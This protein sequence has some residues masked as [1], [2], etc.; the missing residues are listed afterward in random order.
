MMAHPATTFEYCITRIASLRVSL[1]VRVAVPQEPPTFRL[2]LAPP[3]PSTFLPS[4]RSWPYNTLLYHYASA[5]Q[6][7]EKHHQVASHNLPEGGQ[8]RDST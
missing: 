8:H 4:T 3:L 6:K 2:F 1:G 5:L 7:E